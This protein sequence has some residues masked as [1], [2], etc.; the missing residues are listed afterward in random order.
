MNRSIFAWIISAAAAL[1][2]LTACQS[3]YYMLWENLGKE[4]RHLLKSNVEKAKEE[5]KQT[6]K[7]FQTVIEQ[8]KE[9]YG[10]D[11]KQVEAFYAHLNEDYTECEERAEEV[12]DRIDSVERIAKDLFIEWEKEIEEIAN[13]KLKADSKRSLEETRKRYER[14]H[15]AMVKAEE[16]MAPVLRDLKDYVLYLK[17]NLNALAVTSLKEEVQSIDIQVKSLIEKMNRSINEADSFLKTINS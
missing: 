2:F 10:F 15:V 14:L 11:G 16:S 3:T 1:F 6:S 9:M 8:I 12:R 17:H 13:P 4:K 5:Q 7:Q